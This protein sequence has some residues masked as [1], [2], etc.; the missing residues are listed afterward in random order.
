ME[1]YQHFPLRVYGDVLYKAQKQLYVYNLRH[2]LRWMLK[3]YLTKY[4]SVLSLAETDKLI[5]GFELGVDM[6]EKLMLS[7]FKWKWLGTRMRSH[8]VCPKRPNL[9]TIFHGNMSKKK[10]SVLFFSVEH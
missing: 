1:F 4:I 7:V 10:T 3:S 9:L 2:F 6:S 8:Q 5:V